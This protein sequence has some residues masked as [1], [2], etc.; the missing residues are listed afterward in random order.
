MN[1]N[2]YIRISQNR[3]NPPFN[4]GLN[5]EQVH[6]RI[7]TKLTNKSNKKGGKTYLQIILKNFITFF[8]IIY[9]LIALLLVSADAGIA[10]FVFVV[11]VCVNTL[12]GTV[13]EIRSKYTIDKLSIMTAPKAVVVRMGTKQEINIEEIVLDDILYLTP[14]KQIPSD[15]IL[16][17]GEIEVNES[18][19]TGESVPIKKQIG[20][21]VYSG[22]FVVSG[23]C[24]AKV[25]RVGKDNAISQLTSQAKTYRKPQSE[26]LNSLNMWLRIVAVFL[27]IS[28]SI[29]FINS[30]TFNNLIKLVFTNGFSFV[31]PNTGV[32]DFALKESYRISTASAPFV[33]SAVVEK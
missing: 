14:G 25:E 33:T 1:K 15:S 7:E 13:Q 8:N 6:T 9:F 21:T 19:L 5:E 28:G 32:Y 11:L 30:F 16:V 3:Y 27:I 20:D 10:D 2:K 29:M 31:D 18:Q 23:N 22:T 26:I 17:E 12:I 4:Y 24:H